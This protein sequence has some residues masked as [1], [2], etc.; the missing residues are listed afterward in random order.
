MEIFETTLR[1]GEQAASIHLSPMQ[2]AMLAS[3]LEDAGVDV[4]DAGFPFASTADWEGVREVAAATNR[5]RLSAVATHL[6]K[7]ID[8]VA[9][10]LKGHE[11]R[12]RL[13][14]RIG[15][16]E[17]YRK[18]ADKKSVRA[19]LL[20]RS[21]AAV[22]YASGF[23]RE[24]QYYLNY[25][26]NRD[27]DFLEELTGTVVDAGATHVTVADS[28]STLTPPGI[29][30]LV[31]RLTHGFGA[32]AMIGVH[33]HNMFGLSLANTI[34]AVEAGAG[35]VEVTIAGVGDAGGNAS[36]EQ[37]AAYA[38]VFGKDDP[39]WSS[40]FQLSAVTGL[41]NAL[42]SMTG[43]SIASNQPFIGDDTFKI[44]AGIH[45]T[46]LEQ[47]AQGFDPR[48]VGRQAEVVLGRHSGVAGIKQR[49]DQLGLWSSDVNPQV[50]Y[51]ILI[52]GAANTGTI[53]DAALAAAI[54]R[55]RI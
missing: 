25:S 6:K 31:E 51:R 10:A 28:Q 9:R 19:Q 7:D 52:E 45:Q 1:D 54:D 30:A 13:A 17:L 37:V 15:P 2:K 35:Q 53:S 27:P 42:R 43:I 34:A 5:V 49:A 16:R 33:C 41:A 21:A 40:R 48:L 22:S 23:F 39:R 4:I 26:G 24:V 3:A 32:R 29:A 38:A 12:S 18:Y 55:A 44:E 46:Q 11:T 8:G 20:D 50:V 36:L 47:V 14:T